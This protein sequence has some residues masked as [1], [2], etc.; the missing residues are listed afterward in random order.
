[1]DYIDITEEV[2]R[3]AKPYKGKVEKQKFYEYKHKKYIVDGRKVVYKHNNREIEVAK[4]LNKEF[5]GNVKILPNINYPQGIKT[6]DYLY[7]G[8]RLDLKII[9]SKRANDCVKTALRNNE[10]QAN[11]FI[12][13]NTAQNVKD[14][15]IVKQ[16]GEIYKS[17]GFKWIDK[18]YLLN[19]AKFIKIFKRKQ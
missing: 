17:K 8:E 7:K 5:G 12:I 6:P 18:I 16:I 9:T 13:D 19:G 15:Q 4:I 1:M 2:Y 10:E 14:T 11:N 3:N